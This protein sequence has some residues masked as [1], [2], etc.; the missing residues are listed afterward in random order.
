MGVRFEVFGARARRVSPS[1]PSCR[2]GDLDRVTPGQGPPEPCPPAYRQRQGSSREIRTVEP[3]CEVVQWTMFDAEIATARGLAPEA[4]SAA[5]T[6]RAPGIS[7]FKA[8]LRPSSDVSASYNVPVRLAAA[9]RPSRYGVPASW[10][11]HRVCG[12]HRPPPWTA[13]E[14]APTR[15]CRPQRSRPRQQPGELE[16]VRGSCGPQRRIAMRVRARTP[17]SAPSA[18]RR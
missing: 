11:G 1:A 4:T 6:P 7:T 18:R 5:G 13:W 2:N 16:R 15:L 12:R 8:S 14:C 10:K 9:C 17:R 3:S